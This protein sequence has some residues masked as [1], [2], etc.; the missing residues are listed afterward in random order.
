MKALAKFFAS[1]FGSGYAPF[2]PGT[3]GS[4]LASLIV[5][6]LYFHLNV[7]NH[8]LLTFLIAASVIGTIIGVI[9]CDIVESDWGKDPSKVV[10]DEMVGI[11]ISLIY[12]P[13]SASTILL[14]LLLFRIFDIWKPLGIRKLE[15]IK[16]GVGVMADDILAGIYANIVLQL[17]LYLNILP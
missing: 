12:I 15:A 10:L 16:G 3:A 5:Y 4:I 2:A 9:C 8:G 1:G 7:K 6:I 11:F 13:V 14:S 17:I